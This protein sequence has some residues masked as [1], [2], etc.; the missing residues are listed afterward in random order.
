MKT[1]KRGN[2]NHEWQKLETEKLAAE[3]PCLPL[4]ASL[5]SLTVP[6]TFEPPFR[7]VMETVFRESSP[8]GPD[9]MMACQ[10]M[11]I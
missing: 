4:K 5:P 2:E 8:S 1:E 9:P 10:S 3:K 6:V 7:Q 11:E